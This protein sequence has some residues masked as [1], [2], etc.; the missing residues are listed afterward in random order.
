METIDMSDA[1]FEK[2]EY[3]TLRKE[4]ESCMSELGTLEK[5]VV[6]GVAA[7]FAWA[8]K[9]GSM[10]GQLAA[11]A[12]MVPSVIALYGGLKAKAIA[13]HLEVLGSYLREIEKT[14]IQQNSKVQGWQKYFKEN[15]SGKRTQITKE[16]WIGFFILTVITSVIGLAKS[17]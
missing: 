16:A 13:S 15:G 2:A 7:I 1:W 5:T 12:W 14:Q 4:V 10:S 9:D 6:G 8:A 11:V 17:I 3:A